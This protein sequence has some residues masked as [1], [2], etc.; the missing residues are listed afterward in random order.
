[1]KYLSDEIM[2]AMLAKVQPIQAEIVKTGHSAHLDV[3]VNDNI[4]DREYGHHI[5]FSMDIF[6]GTDLIESFDFSSSGSEEELNAEFGRMQ[7]YVN[8]RL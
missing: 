8:N 3:A 4:F 6:Y 5:S 7:A 1:M 2:L